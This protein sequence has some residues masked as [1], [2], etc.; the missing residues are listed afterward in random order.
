MLYDDRQAEFEAFLDQLE[1]DRALDVLGKIA[2]LQG[3][4][5]FNRAA[6]LDA[7]DGGGRVA[8]LQHL[9]AVSDRAYLEGF[10][11][12]AGFTPVEF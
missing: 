12:V 1:G 11:K 4:Q 5:D 2:D 3:R 6:A 7:R 8:H 9:Q 10:Q